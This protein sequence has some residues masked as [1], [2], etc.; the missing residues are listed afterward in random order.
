MLTNIALLAEVFVFMSSGNSSGN[1]A[2]TTAL[3]LWK[4]DGN[5]EDFRSA[6]CK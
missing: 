3:S 4:R 6:Y 5:T 2:L 1:S